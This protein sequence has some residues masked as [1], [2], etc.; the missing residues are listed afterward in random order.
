VHDGVGHRRA[1]GQLIFQNAVQLE[2]TVK[3]RLRSWMKQ[4]KQNFAHAKTLNPKEVAWVRLDFE[5]IYIFYAQLSSDAAHPFIEHR[6][7]VPHRGDKAGGVDIE[8]VVRRDGI[9]AILS[10]PQSWAYASASIKSSAEHRA[11]GAEPLG[12]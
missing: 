12:R 3:D 7:L 11:A 10:V 8:P 5:K 4:A 2:T 1:R 6:Y 9:N